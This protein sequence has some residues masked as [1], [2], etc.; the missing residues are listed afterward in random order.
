VYE[1]PLTDREPLDRWTDGCVT[2]LGD[3][4]HAMYPIGSNGASQSILDAVAL[5]TAVAQHGATP[6]ALLAYEA[7]R[8][9]PTTRIVLANRGNGPEQVMELAEQRA[10]DGFDDIEQVIPRVELEE[11]AA[12]YKQLAGFSISQVEGK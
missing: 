7:E 2:L 9:E 10:P 6:A 3:A 4:A 5:A 1:Y 11:I 8:R 12:Q